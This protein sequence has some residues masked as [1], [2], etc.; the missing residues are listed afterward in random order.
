MQIVCGNDVELRVRFAFGNSWELSYWNGT[1]QDA[2]YTAGTVESNDSYYDID[3]LISSDANGTMKARLAINQ[4][5]DPTAISAA[6]AITIPNGATIGKPISQ[7]TAFRLGSLINGGRTDLFMGGVSIGAAWG[8]S[9]ILFASFNNG[10]IQQTDPT[11]LPP[12]RKYAFTYGNAVAGVSVSAGAAFVKNGSS[13]GN[14]NPL[15]FGFP[16]A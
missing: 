7:I 8:G 6:A 16:N 4:R 10:A 13:L 11:E 9:E 3:V 2:V 12:T 1:L 5:N 14:D 15:G